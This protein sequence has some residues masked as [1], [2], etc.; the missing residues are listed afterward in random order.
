MIRWGILLLAVVINL[1]WVVSSQGGC[2]VSWAQIVPKEIN[3]FLCTNLEVQ[4]ALIRAVE[5]G[6]HQMCNTLPNIWLV[7][8]L[9]LFNTVV[10]AVVIFAPALTLRAKG[11]ARKRAVH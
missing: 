2:F 7:A 4:A 11:A 1:F 10:V 6:R 3:C 8:C 5:I 9:A